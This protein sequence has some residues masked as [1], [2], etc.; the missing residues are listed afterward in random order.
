MPLKR[1]PPDMTHR[2]A[3]LAL[4]SLGL[5][6]IAGGA[7][8]DG[9]EASFGRLAGRL[10]AD[11]HNEYGE[12]ETGLDLTRFT[13]E[14]QLRADDAALES[15]L[16]RVESGS[17]PPAKADQPTDEERRLLVA[18][19]ERTLLDV[20]GAEPGDPGIVVMPRLS[21]EEYDRVVAQLTGRRIEASRYLPKDPQAGEGFLNVGAEQAVTAGQIEKYLDAANF[22]LKHAVVT[23]ERGLRWY[24]DPVGP[25]GTPAQYR[26]LLVNEWVAEM[27]EADS[28]LVGYWGRARQV[29]WR[30]ADV[31]VSLWKYRFLSERGERFDSKL[32]PQPPHGD[33]I[34]PTVLRNWWEMLTA[35]D[36]GDEQFRRWRTTYFADWFDL[37]SPGEID[38]R[39]VRRIVDRTLAPLSRMEESRPSGRQQEEQVDFF[40]KRAWKPGSDVYFTI[41]TGGRS[42]ENALAVVTRT[43]F[44]F[45]KTGGP[46]D[47]WRQRWP[48]LVSLDG[49]RFAWGEGRDGFDVGPDEAIVE[50]PATF[51]VP[52]PDGCWAIRADVKL[53]R[54][55][56]PDTWAQP[57]FADEP[58][59]AEELVYKSGESLLGIG[60]DY[61]NLDRLNTIRAYY[62]VPGKP[63]RRHQPY[64]AFHEFDAVPL[65]Y[66][67]AAQWPNVRIEDGRVTSNAEESVLGGSALRPRVLTAKQIRANSP[68]AIQTRFDALTGDL[69]WSAQAPLQDLREL[70]VRHGDEA[71][72]EGDVPAA[73]EVA[74]WSAADR[75]AYERLLGEAASFETKLEGPARRIVREF[76]ERAWRRSVHDAELDR[77]ISAYRAERAIGGSFDA[78]VKQSLKAVTLSPDF[79]FRP[80]SLAGQAGPDERPLSDLAV[81]NRL[82]FTLWGAGPDDELLRLADER[83]L[84][85][86]E[87]LRRQVRRMLADERSRALATDFAGQWLGYADFDG[88]TRPNPERFPEYDLPLREAMNAEAV[89]FL[90]DLFAEDRPLTNLIDADYTFANERLAKFYGIDGVSGDRMRRVEIPESLRGRRGGLFG[91]AAVLT[92]TSTALR[93]SPVL[94]GAWLYKTVLGNPMPDPPPDVEMIS[95]DETDAAGRTIAEQLAHHRASAV[96]ASCHDRLD[97]PGIALEGFDPIGRWRDSYLAGTDVIDRA[98]LADGDTIAGPAGLRTYLRD[99]RRQFLRQFARKFLG[100]ALGR[101]LLIT[102]KPL[103]AQ[104]VASLEANDLRPGP[105]IETV[106]LSRP[107]LFRRDAPAAAPSE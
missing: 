89:A 31:L 72:V 66:L 99:N 6:A 93:T 103:V 79:L 67:D 2:V 17:M 63:Y 34:P 5:P 83:R 85:D 106:V 98:D 23:P 13:D 7:E 39:R 90:H 11:C 14:A 15:I 92:R 46:G 59:T 20:R 41:T 42:R 71:A 77:L 74:G 82:A 19:L 80:S 84:T 102:D 105:M 81:A 35:K 40:G 53:D 36:V 1:I 49:R 95:A 16:E 33:P 50:L 94:R 28:D 51:K 57:F 101:E 73:A 32:V 44:R 75:D 22:V 26:T 8:K 45:D 25:L 104:M 3:I 55:L 61:E 107:Y 47:R 78:A 100:Y 68:P 69:R 24:D 29:D 18:Y 65:R 4:L 76:A 87:E 88:H 12:L 30:N 21:H 10:C 9:F 91:M 38:E 56:S 43:E 62:G 86:P 27:R 96:C 60:E 64:L 54:R 58:P 70:A 52:V 48:T 37:P 97:P